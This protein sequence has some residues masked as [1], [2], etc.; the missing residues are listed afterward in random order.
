MMLLYRR[1]TVLENSEKSPRTELILTLHE[2]PKLNKMSQQVN[3]TITPHLE[4]NVVPG[5]T[6]LEVLINVGFLILSRF[7]NVLLPEVV[8][9]QSIP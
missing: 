2:V 1:L 7:V 8:V 3:D 4:S 5:H 9:I 6:H